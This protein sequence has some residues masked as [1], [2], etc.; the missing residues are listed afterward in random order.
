[1]ILLE[2]E[3]VG[4]NYGCMHTRSIHYMAIPKPLS[5]ISRGSI[6]LCTFCSTST[7]DYNICRVSPPL[8]IGLTLF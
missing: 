7:R 3:V 1:M 2:L 5:Y 4:S 8:L 6:T